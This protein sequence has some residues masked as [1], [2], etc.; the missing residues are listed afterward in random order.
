MAPAWAPSWYARWPLRFNEGA[1]NRAIAQT[2]DGRYWVASLK[3]GLVWFDGAGKALKRFVEVQGEPGAISALIANP[4]GSL[5]VGTSDNGLWKYVPPAR[6]PLPSD[7]TAVPAPETGTWTR[8]SGI[9]GA[10]VTR[11][12][13]E[14]RSGKRQLFVGTNAGLVVYT[15]E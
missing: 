8:V 7:P 11:I 6:A 9:P 13:L 3:Y 2:P 5:W 1:D 10:N 15:P 12:H 14:T 4:D